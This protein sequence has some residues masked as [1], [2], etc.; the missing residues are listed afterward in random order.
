M[1]YEEYI[2]RHQRVNSNTAENSVII[3]CINVTIYTFTTTTGHKDRGPAVAYR[4]NSISSPSICTATT[5]KVCAKA[6]LTPDC[7]MALVCAGRV[8]SVL[9]VQDMNSTHVDLIVIQRSC[10]SFLVS[11]KRVSPAF[12]LAIIP[13]LDT[14][15]SV[16]VDFP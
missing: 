11:V 8:Y 15:E 13:A 4:S 7:N 5:V 10:S 12:A 6:S 1:L 14:R 2:I 16:S 3:I 9:L